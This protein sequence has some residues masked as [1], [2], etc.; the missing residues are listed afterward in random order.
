MDDTV[1]VD[2]PAMNDAPRS[3][4]LS[5][6]SLVILGWTVVVSTTILLSRFEPS[7]I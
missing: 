5:L 2:L 3:L 1:S 4:N 6:V 7:K